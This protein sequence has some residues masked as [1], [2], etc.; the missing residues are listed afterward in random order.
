MARYLSME[1]IAW[2]LS[3]AG[4]AGP[5][6]EN[7]TAIAW[8]ESGGQVDAVGDGGNS[9]GLFQVHV[10]SHPQYDA[11]KLR[12][13]P[14]Y[15]AKAAWEISGQGRNLNPWTTWSHA[16]A[17]GKKHNAQQ[18][19][20]KAKLAVQAVPYVTKTEPTGNQQGD[21]NPSTVSTSGVDIKPAV[22][23]KDDLPPD[24]TPEQIE[25]WVRT[26]LPNVAPFLG[27]DEIRKILLA[28]DIDEID[29]LELETRLRKT[30]YWQTHGRESRD[31][32]RLIADDKNAA[33]QLVDRAK[34]LLSD[35]F[36]K[37]GVA[38]DDKKLGTVAKNA[39]RA[40]WIN[41]A[42][43]V[44][45]QDALN[46]F[47]AFALGVQSGDKEFAPG[48]AAISA[49]ALEATARKYGQTLPQAA[50]KD[51]TLKILQGQATSEMFSQY[52]TRL[53]K[54]HWKHDADVM[55][56]LDD[57][58]T[59]EDH[60]ASHAATIAKTLELADDQV[61]LFGDP[62]WQ[63]VTQMF[64]PELKAKR[65]MTLGEAANLARQDVRY[66]KTRAYQSQ[67]AEFALRL[68]EFLGKA[69]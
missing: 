44:E 27:N 63:Q 22:L 31:F 65:S 6:L 37:L 46:D 34:A 32:D 23:P 1:Q 48:G 26:N 13:D 67:D 49:E 4:F 60:F 53:A 33:I 69:V 29:D 45:D 24:A 50:L 14:S 16:T 8:A 3:R 39:I 30:K 47:A 41:Q 35:Q 25:K 28:P 17:A 5:T 15:A 66:T 2:H 58:L 9:H 56:S 61:D 38:A 21:A 7:M 36:A 19:L 55:G 40:G 42:G 52:V 51:W 20:E 11:A 68:G 62:K 59:L 43:E 64:D 12:S 57:G 54:S 10:P 18:Y